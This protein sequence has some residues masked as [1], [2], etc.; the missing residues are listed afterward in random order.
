MMMKTS[1]I[2]S[3]FHAT[4]YSFLKGKGEKKKEKKESAIECN[5]SAV[6]PSSGV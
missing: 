6:R 4:N 1:Q 5:V 3:S 2:P